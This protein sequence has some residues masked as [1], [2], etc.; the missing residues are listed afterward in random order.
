MGRGQLTAVSLA[1]VLVGGLGAAAAAAD[2]PAGGV[3][4]RATLAIEG[5]PS[6]PVPLEAVDALGYTFLDRD[7]PR[8]LV[9]AINGCS[10]S[11]RFWVLAANL[12]DEPATLTLEAPDGVVFGPLEL[13]ARAADGTVDPV[14]SLRG[15]P[16]CAAFEEAGGGITPLDGS[17]RFSAVGPSCADSTR[18]ITLVPRTRNV[19][20]REVV[21]GGGPARRVISTEPVAVIDDAGRDRSLLLI[22]E[23]RLPGR[24]EGVIF[25]GGSRLLPAP[26]QLER[27]LR[28]IT[29]GRVRRAF[30]AAVNDVRPRP[31]I[32]DLG[33]RD[34]RCVH[35]VDLDFDDRDASERLFAAGWL[36]DDPDRIASI[37]TGDEGDRG[38]S[39]NRAAAPDRRFVVE[40]I[41]LG[42]RFDEIPRL[43]GPSERR[44]SIATWTFQDIDSLAQVIDACELTG[45]YWTL[46]G[47]RTESGFEASFR[48]LIGRASTAYP[49]AQAVGGALSPA[50]IDPVAFTTC[51]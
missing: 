5:E 47:S 36:K 26:G 21:I 9:Q 12:G 41:D 15:L 2:A 40:T 14:V 32:A 19:G 10:L 20:F 27:R 31:I 51:E 1:A 49:V 11:G 6:Q 33:L 28:G 29:D 42:G 8:A 30:E 13:P 4:V 46:L 48:D 3:E 50:V 44:S 17:A 7:D 22:A 45:T 38:D 35:H 16:I 25:S 24:V 37:D 43:A 34:V 39:S 23:G 18:A